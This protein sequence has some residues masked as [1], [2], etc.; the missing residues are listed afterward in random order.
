MPFRMPAFIPVTMVPTAFV[1]ACPACDEGVEV[2]AVDGD[3]S[4]DFRVPDEDRF[5][6]CRNCGDLIE[7]RGCRVTSLDAPR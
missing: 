7:I 3:I 2:V 1:A 4:G 5:T 6:S